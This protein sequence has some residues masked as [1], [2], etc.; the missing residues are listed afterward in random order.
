MEGQVWTEVEVA[1]ENYDLT[2]FN[3]AA[4]KLLEQ[5]RQR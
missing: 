4:D 2:D 3:K 5:E 1:D